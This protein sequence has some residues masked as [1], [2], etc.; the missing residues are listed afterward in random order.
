[1]TASSTS[2]NVQISFHS[3][4]ISVLFLHLQLPC[5][6]LPKPIRVLSDTSPAIPA[7]P[8]PFILHPLQDT[9]LT[10]YSLLSPVL[11]LSALPALPFPP[12]PSLSIPSFPTLL[13]SSP[14]PPPTLHP[15]AIISP[16][17]PILVACPLPVRSYHVPSPSSPHLLHMSPIRPIHYQPTPPS[18]IMPNPIWIPSS[19]IFKLSITFYPFRLD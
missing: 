12:L 13:V 18:K 1:M 16:N 9:S 8:H 19:R 3:C 2:W 17:R 15:T 6:P 4:T 14:H 5:A 7:P 11:A 10:S